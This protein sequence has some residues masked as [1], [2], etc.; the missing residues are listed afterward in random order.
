MHPTETI[1]LRKKKRDQ[2]GEEN[3]KTPKLYS[4]KYPV[5]FKLVSGFCKLEIDN[6]LTALLL[7]YEGTVNTEHHNTV[8]SSF[9]LPE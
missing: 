3:K 5:I 2:N 4:L 8:R 1:K 9:T 6:A 7:L